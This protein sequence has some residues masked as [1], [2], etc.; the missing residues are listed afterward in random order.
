MKRLVEMQ[1]VAVKRFFFSQVRPVKG[2]M[3]FVAI[4]LSLL[5]HCSAQIVELN[6]DLDILVKV[7]LVDVTV[8]YSSGD[9]AP[10]YETFRCF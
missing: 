6:P 2:T 10:T 3:I 5:V 7:K 4:L 8:Q 1:F 9:A